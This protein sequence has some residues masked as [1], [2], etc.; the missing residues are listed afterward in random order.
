MQNGEK[1]GMEKKQCIIFGTTDFG[2][3]LR[4]Y[5]EKFTDTKIAAYAVDGA[6]KE[7]DNYDGLP[8]VEFEKMEENYSA[9]KYLLMLALGYSKMN[10]IRGKK[11]YEAKEKGYTLASFIHPSAGQSYAEIGEGNI[12]LENVTL[13]YGSKIGDGNIVWNGCQISHE[14]VIGDFNYF[15]P[16]VVVAGKT[17]VKNNCFLG[18]NSAVR[19]ARTLEDYTLVGAG[20]YMNNSSTPY[21]VYVPARSICLE[22]KRSTDMM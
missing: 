7:T 11:F 22:N 8:V 20:C 4:Y 3:M 18:I 15:A 13:A 21:S 14:C 9:D 6:Y 17:I 16:G 5:M 2:K 19:G 1:C 10:N 12:V